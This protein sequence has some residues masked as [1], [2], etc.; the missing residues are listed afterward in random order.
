MCRQ[1]INNITARV[2]EV[3]R[4]NGGHIERL[5]HRGLISSFFMLVSSIVVEIKIVLIDQILDH[6][7]P[8]S[9]YYMT[10]L[11]ALEKLNLK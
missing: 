1:V 5:I 6:V 11:H 8:Q 2:E 4:R 3:A 10:L 9:V 7:V